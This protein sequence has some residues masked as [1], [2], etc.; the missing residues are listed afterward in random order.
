[1]QGRCK[2]ASDEV[3]T[4]DALYVSANGDGTITENLSSEVVAR[5]VTVF[6]VF[7]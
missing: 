5:I 7:A 6:Y 4:P 2:A 1:M 3:I